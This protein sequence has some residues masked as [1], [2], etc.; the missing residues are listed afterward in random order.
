MRCP[1]LI[2]LPQGLGV[3]GVNLWAVRLAEVVAERGRAVAL[4]VHREP[5]GPVRLDVPIHP[6]VE[7][8][9]LTATPPLEGARG[10]LTPWTDHYRDTV[11]RLADRAGGPVILSPNLLGDCYGIAAALCP[12]TLRGIGWHHSAID[13]TDRVRAH[14]EP[15]L[16]RFVAVSD[17]IA[18]RLE[19]AVPHRAA[20]VV[21]IPY[22]VNVP[23]ELPSRPALT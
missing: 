23:R 18:T 2:A 14:Y 7:V 16:A 12:Q 19:A 11:R 17:H 3:S 4:V 22:G 9:D 6:A 21:N 15:I 20:D 13:Y 1:L 10:D 8:V 5:P